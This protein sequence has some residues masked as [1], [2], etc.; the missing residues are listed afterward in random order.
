MT[1]VDISL[2]AYMTQA[3]SAGQDIRFLDTWLEV[4]ATEQKTD[5]QPACSGAATQ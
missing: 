1:L 2:V 5:Q 3:T 4:V